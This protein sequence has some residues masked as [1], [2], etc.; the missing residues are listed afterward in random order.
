MNIEVTH[1]SGDRPGAG[2]LRGS[3]RVLQIKGAQVY[4]LWIHEHLQKNTPLNQVVRDR[5]SISPQMH[6]FITA[7]M[8]KVAK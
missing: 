6:D 3:R 4:R 1:L 2:R 5:L 7:Y 8:K